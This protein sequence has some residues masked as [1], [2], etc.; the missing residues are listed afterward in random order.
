M[1]LQPHSEWNALIWSRIIKIRFAQC[2]H[3]FFQIFGPSLFFNPL[4]FSE[5]ASVDLLICLLRKENSWKCVEGSPCLPGIFLFLL[6]WFKA[7]KKWPFL[8][9]FLRGFIKAFLWQHNNSYCFPGEDMVANREPCK[10]VEAVWRLGN[11]SA[12]MLW[13][14]PSMRVL[15]WHT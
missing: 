14:P 9:P 4:H 1:Y 12:G 5:K 6:Y 15:P 2:A 7:N 8:S 13:V 10:P 3:V 11:C